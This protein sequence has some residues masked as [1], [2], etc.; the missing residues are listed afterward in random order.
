VLGSVIGGSRCRTVRLPALFQPYELLVNRGSALG[1]FVIA[2]PGFAW[3][4]SVLKG[5]PGLLAGAKYSRP[6]LPRR[7]GPAV[8]TLF[9]KARGNPALMSIE[10]DIEAPGPAPSSR[11]TRTS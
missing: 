8:F 9:D 11:S 6:N 7:V 4:L 2:Q 5:I 1:A 3:V 10:G